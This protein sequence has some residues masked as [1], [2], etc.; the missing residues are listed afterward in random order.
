MP[1]ARS[2]G[3][4]LSSSEA[5]LKHLSKSLPPKH[6]NVGP[7]IGLYASPGM[8]YVAGTWASWMSGGV[9]V[10]LAVTHPKHELEYV[11]QDAGI[12]AVSR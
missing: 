4:L 2:Y 5:I 12:S 8:P 6:G 11:I 7:R 10:P 9:V 3:H 1:I